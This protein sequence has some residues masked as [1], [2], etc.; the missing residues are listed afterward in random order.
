MELGRALAM[1]KSKFSKSDQ[2][3]LDRYQFF[4]ELLQED[5]V[6]S[7]PHYGLE[8]TVSNLPLTPKTKVHIISLPIFGLDL[9][10]FGL[11]QSSGYRFPVISFPDT[12]VQS[13]LK[14]LNGLEPDVYLDTLFKCKSCEKYF[15][16]FASEQKYW[17]ETLRFN[18]NAR[19]I[20]CS[21]CRVG[22]KK[23]KNASKMLAEF[24]LKDELSESERKDLERASSILFEAGVIKKSGTLQKIRNKIKK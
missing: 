21:P 6:A 24:I 2:K 8:P 1:S 9:S 14:E 5:K 20:E 23:I 15:I 19:P 7:H 11:E 18:I 16:F 10:Q 4:L 12:A 13:D 22:S 3:W 17:Y